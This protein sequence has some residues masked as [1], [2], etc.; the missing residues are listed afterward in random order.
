MLAILVFDY[1]VAPP[2]THQMIH[3]NSQVKQPV[4]TAEPNHRC[5]FTNW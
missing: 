4:P 3:K 5:T 1:F 2:N